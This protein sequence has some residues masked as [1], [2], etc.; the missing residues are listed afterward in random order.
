MHQPC[1]FVALRRVVG[2]GHRVVGHGVGLEGAR[3]AAAESRLDVVGELLLRH[4]LDLSAAA[5]E[6]RVPRGL[7]HRQEPHDVEAEGLAEAAA[8]VLQ[9]VG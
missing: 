5:V 7:G 4:E 9:D 6:G 2:R 3:E 8:G 1:R